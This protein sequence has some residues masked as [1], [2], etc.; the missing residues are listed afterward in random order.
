MK[1]FSDF[2]NNFSLI[3]FVGYSKKMIQNRNLL[4]ILI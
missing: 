4:K 2:Y 1:V 3:G